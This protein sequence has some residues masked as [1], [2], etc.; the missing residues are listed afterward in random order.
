MT[1]ASSAAQTFLP[2]AR[3]GA[4][5]AT[6]S[7][8]AIVARAS[9]HMEI[10]RSANAEPAQPL[11]GYNSGHYKGAP[12]SSQESIASCAGIRPLTDPNGIHRSRPL[13][14]IFL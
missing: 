5:F 14:F 13:V 1:P 7:K 6:G 12:E 8:A 4:E 9:I 10:R 3:P 2:A 11:L